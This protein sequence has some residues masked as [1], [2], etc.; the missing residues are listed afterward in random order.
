MGNQTGLFV[1]FE[2]MDGSGKSTH[3]AYLQRLLE[4]KGRTVRLTREPGGSEFAEVIREQVLFAPMG[5]W[6][7]MLAVAAARRDHL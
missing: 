1:V 6:T 3:I 5:P 7:E 4:G 2:G